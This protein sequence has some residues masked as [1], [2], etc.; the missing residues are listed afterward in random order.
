MLSSVVNLIIG[1]FKKGARSQTVAKLLG[2]LLAIQ[3]LVGGHGPVP[4]T[5]EE[6]IGLINIIL[7][8]FGVGWTI[9]KLQAM[10]LAK[11]NVSPKELEEAHK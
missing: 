3:Q 8:G 1:L 7:A 6:V 9:E 5:L 10:W 11:H 2:M 4:W